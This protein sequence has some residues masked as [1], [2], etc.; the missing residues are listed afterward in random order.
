MP[1]V[2]T[3]FSHFLYGGDYNPEQWPRDVWTEDVRLMNEANVTIATLPVFGWVSLQPDEDTYTFEWLDEVL[4][5]LAA[6]GVK[7]CM[8]TATASVPA[9]VT[10]K[11]PDILT[12]DDMGVRRRHGNRHTFCPNSANFRRLS[13]NL[14]RKIAERYK[15]HPALLLWHVSNEYGTYCWC[16]TCAAA[17]RVW[18]QAKY[19]E[20]ATLN[21]RWYTTF[22]GHTYTDWAQIEP[23]YRNG[24]GAVQALK[25]DW[26]RFQSESLLNCYRAEAAVLREVT[27]DIPITTNLMGTFYPLNYHAWAKE[28]DIVSWDSYPPQGSPP[29]HVAFLHSVMRGL[30]DGQPFLLMEQSPSQQ[31]WQH[32][33]TVK[34]PGELRLQ[35][36]QA[37]AHGADSVMYFQWRRGQG[38]IEKL[39]GAIVEHH[40]NTD[41]RVF[42][43]VKALGG[44]LKALGADPLGKR[45]P[46]KVA[47]LF[48]WENW[49]GLSFSSG[50]T[51]DLSYV[52]LV[53]SYFVALWSLGVQVDVLRPDADLSGYDLI[54]APTLSMLTL[55]QAEQLQ[56]GVAAGATLLATVFSALTDESDLV[57]PG[58]A[59]GPLRDVLGLWVE[60]TDAVMA[61]DK[62]GIRLSDGTTFE[63]S[64]LCD[65]VRL[66][67][68]ET[69]AT[70]TSDF[71]AGEPA[72]TKNV[73]GEGAAY[74]I[75]THPEAAGIRH[76]LTTI[77]AE[78][79]IASPLANGAAPPAGV[80]VTQRGELLYLLNHGAPTSVSLA[81]GGW[82]DLLTGETL[83]GSTSL[84]TRDVR[85]L[86]PQ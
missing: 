21:A 82:T 75:A 70:Y 30:K 24:E 34:L 32:Y 40:A 68:A 28:L 13:T 8:A 74:Y 37:I 27:P 49:W 76:L 15:D 17:F 79:N 66:T 69:L 14:A 3:N 11:Y 52:E 84:G 86:R 80:E 5:K 83:T 19:T 65:R 58:G 67:T 43:E 59:P 6:G 9:W 22:W 54:V 16:E 50:P 71:Y 61:S 78:K 42:Q 31:N 25:L 55:A 36:Y 64:L 44:E 41:T 81:P 39:H 38:G 57:H 18:L 1:S 48:S 26:Y 72:V 20:L 73:Y 35:S 51:R 77:C 47:L 85:I 46:A 10:Q 33:N 23:P 63:A 60:E 12:A 45:V 4:D 62:N 53:R 2:N 7:V 56:N 29:A